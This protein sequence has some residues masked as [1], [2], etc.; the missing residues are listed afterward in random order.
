M[1]QCLLLTTL[2]AR[3]GTAGENATLLQPAMSDVLSLS[4]T[5]LL[6]PR[7]DAIHV[8]L[9]VFRCPC[10]SIQVRSFVLVF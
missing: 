5:G 10:V 9:A 2:L 1:G 3:E 4:F 7:H 6:L 8:Q